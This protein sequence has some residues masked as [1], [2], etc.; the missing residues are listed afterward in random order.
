MTKL[1]QD[2]IEA[3]QHITVYTGRKMKVGPINHIIEIEDTAFKGSVLKVECV[4]LP[5]V[6]VK[7]LASWDGQPPERNKISLDSR[8]MSFKRLSEEYVRSMT[9]KGHRSKWD[10]PNIQ[11]V[12]LE[13]EDLIQ[14]FLQTKRERDGPP[15][16]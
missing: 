11:V 1:P 2:D 12:P 4:D 13:M 7:E 14:S 3:G 5:Y 9:S 10:E 6:V 15:Q 16:H 8:G